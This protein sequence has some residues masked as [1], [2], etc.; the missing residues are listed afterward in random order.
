MR[1]PRHIQEYSGLPKSLYILFFARIINSMGN[2]VFPFLTLFLTDKIGVGTT[3]AGFYMMLVATAYV[4]GS[5]IGGKITD[6]IGRK[7]VFITFQ[8]LAAISFIPCAFLGNS[9]LI[10]WLLIAATF[11]NG[12]AQPATSAMMADLTTPENRKQ[13]FSL[14]YLGT[15]IGFA[16]GPLI[17][18]FLYNNYIKLIF[19][20]DAATTFIS[21]ILVFIY[22]KETLPSKDDIIESK[23]LDS[24]EKAE[25]GNILLVLLKRPLLLGFAG[26]SIITSFVYAQFSFSV[27]LQANEIFGDNGPKFYG[28]IM[29]TNAVTVIFMTITLTNTTKRIKPILNIAIASILFAIGFG[30]TFYINSL[31]MLIV[32]T[33]IWTLGEI[34]NHTNSGVYIAN[35]TPMSHR[36]RFNAVIPII[37]GAGHAIGPL[38]MGRFIEDNGVRLVWPVLFILSIGAAILMYSLYMLEKRVEKRKLVVE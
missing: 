5:L 32:S 16:V 35:H 4:P 31:I 34:L 11:F 7:K 9:M 26:V 19:L 18:G 38:I 12:A 22:V 36:G 17:A 30:M 21:L 10:P 24:D 29:A 23:T 13:A 27:P 25:E 3:E 1:M 8:A 28:M 37:M 6:H 14:L 20:G 15:N 33:I 2:F